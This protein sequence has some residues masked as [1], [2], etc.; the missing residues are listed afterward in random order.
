MNE[1][2]NLTL[3]N[4]FPCFPLVM[5]SSN[6]SKVNMEGPL[7]LDGF[8]IPILDS[9]PS[10][11]NGSSSSSFTIVDTL[12]VDGRGDDVTL[13]VDTLDVDTFELD[14]LAEEDRR[15]EELRDTRPLFPIAPCSISSLIHSPVP[16]SSPVPHSVQRL[17]LSLS[18]PLGCPG[19]QSWLILFPGIYTSDTC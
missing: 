4:F 14:T 18:L 12:D 16:S 7:L 15:R 13:V 10:S 3:Y 6:I 1:S 11:G 2:I 8:P 5:C 19:F 17:L 9:C